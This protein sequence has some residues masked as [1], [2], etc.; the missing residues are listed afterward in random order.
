MNITIEEA[1]KT[2][3]EADSIPI[4]I[5]YL[6]NATTYVSTD[7]HPAN[8]AS[9]SDLVIYPF[10]ELRASKNPQDFGFAMKYYP[11]CED[12]LFGEEKYKPKTGFGLCY[13]YE[14]CTEDDEIISI[15][16]NG[17]CLGKLVEILSNNPNHPA[18]VAYMR[19]K[20]NGYS[21]QE[22]KKIKQQ[23][24]TECRNYIEALFNSKISLVIKNHPHFDVDWDNLFKYAKTMDFNDFINNTQ[25]SFFNTE[26]L[27]RVID[28][29]Y[30]DEMIRCGYNTTHPW[31]HCCLSI[32]EPGKHYTSKIKKN[33]KEINER[34]RMAPITIDK[35]FTF[36]YA[37]R[38]PIGNEP[39]P[40]ER[41]LKAYGYL[42]YELKHTSTPALDK[43]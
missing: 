25:R 11:N 14:H 43:Q 34:Y 40:Y 12:P 8:R 26:C 17:R 32:N 3:S 42:N 18:N 4:K 37:S 41:F 24:Y 38:T 21:E 1:K 16:Y 15:V 30:F 10:K 33:A 23:K 19:A 31:A 7:H 29:E 39:T 6:E 20:A 13:D 5:P 35:E 22:S 28:P 2:L 36:E 27:I 9:K